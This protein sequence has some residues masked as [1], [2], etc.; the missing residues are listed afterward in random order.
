MVKM[1]AIMPYSAGYY[2]R[3]VCQEKLLNVDITIHSLSS[4]VNFNRDI[5]VLCYF[6]SSQ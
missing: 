2:R 1:S 6:I 5:T 3:G 4:L